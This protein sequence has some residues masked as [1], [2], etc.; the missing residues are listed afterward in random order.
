M[1]TEFVV[2]GNVISEMY[3]IEE[4]DK[5]KLVYD[6][7]HHHMIYK[8]GAPV[9]PEVW[10]HGPLEYNVAV[11]VG[12]EVAS[13]E[14]GGFYYRYTNN[15]YAWIA[16]MDYEEK[17]EIP[18]KTFATTGQ[19]WFGF[20]DGWEPRTQKKT[21]VPANRRAPGKILLEAG[22]FHL[23][24][25][26]FDAFGTRG[27]TV[28][29]TVD[30]RANCQR[31]PIFDEGL[32]LETS[33]FKDVL[34]WQLNLRE[35]KKQTGLTPL[36]M[37]SPRPFYSSA[38]I[39]QVTY[40]LDYVYVVHEKWGTVF[41]VDDEVDAKTGMSLFL[42]VKEA[43][44]RAG[45]TL[46]SGNNMHSGLRSIAF[47]PLGDNDNGRVYASAME[48]APTDPEVK[49]RLPYLERRSTFEPINEESVLVEFKYAQGKGDLDSYRLLFR[50]ECPV[51]DHT[52]R[53][54]GFGN[55]DTTYLYVLHGDG[56]V[57]SVVVGDAQQDDGLGKILRIDPL[58][59]YASL[60]ANLTE[61]QYSTKGNPFDYD[62]NE[63]RPLPAVL[64]PLNLVEPV[65]GPVPKEVFALGFRNPHTM[66]F[67]DDGTFIVGE[68]GR[69][70]FEEINVIVE[71]GNYG[72]S[73]LEGTWAHTQ[74]ADAETNH[75]FYSAYPTTDHCENCHFR[76]PS[77]QVGHAGFEGMRYNS[78]ALA[79]GHVVE[80]ESPLADNG[81]KYF[82]CDFPS[83]G[84]FFYAYLDDL[85]RA[86]SDENNNADYTPAT[87]YK[88]SFSY[89]GVIYPSL[90]HLLYP[91]DHDTFPTRRVDARI[92]RDK[93]GTLYLSSKQT[94]Q[95]FRID[96]SKP[97]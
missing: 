62:M 58:D 80:N 43:M 87:Q 29:V 1:P 85:Q 78:V 88:A 83:T 20:L 77:L 74:L 92:G 61:G 30:I 68:A 54:I 36:H 89:E 25:V 65:M 9:E 86:A 22:E 4:S 11:E 82:F 91:S 63:E 56:S 69:D 50:V 39:S 75:M 35:E 38:R 42:D 71:G 7:G 41:R 19:S 37:V 53:Q 48:P 59:G 55:M 44:E 26:P 81:G 76:P 51:Y 3:V 15:D 49:Q 8:D 93:Q 27:E 46:G 97:T 5:S 21:A 16:T 52:I 40:F 70:S 57:E 24:A 13:L 90:R 95:V 12:A 34:A 18:S 67:A 64:P 47:H 2:S 94:G 17:L 33:L 45:T 23:W 60:E 96:N 10:F 14:L 31:E 79:G 72:W 66:T 6:V 32:V 73:Y 84:N 28:N